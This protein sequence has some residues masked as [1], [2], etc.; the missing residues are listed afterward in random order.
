MSKNKKQTENVTELTVIS[1]E[2]INQEAD[3][4]Q[5]EIERQAAILQ[6]RLAELEQKKQLSDHRN[7]FLSVIE[8][9]NR[10]EKEL[11]KETGFDA[12]G[13]KLKFCHSQNYRDEDVFTIGNREIIA[14]FVNFIRQ[15]VL[16]K[17]RSIEMQLIA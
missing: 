15:K 6:Q 4:L 3:K 16:D 1:T 11:E 9:L 17:I 2:V 10:A 14:D 7:T 13:F 8:N 5:M 12:D